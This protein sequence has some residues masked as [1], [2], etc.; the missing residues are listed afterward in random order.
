[1]ELDL[2]IFP[3]RFGIFGIFLKE[4]VPHLNVRKTVSYFFY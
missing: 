4:I 1:M 3:L 2:R